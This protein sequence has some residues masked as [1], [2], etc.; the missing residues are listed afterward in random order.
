MRLKLTVILITLIIG[1]GF[2]AMQ[3]KQTI[4]FFGDS[5]TEAGVKEGGYISLMKNKLAA[6]GITNYNLE[7]AGIGGNK[8]YDLYLRM[9]EDVLSK[10]PTIVV[11]WVGVNDVWHK[12]T[13]LT[14]TDYD[15]FG[16]F[17][18]A[19]I[20]KL[21]DNNIRVIVCTPA[22]IGEKTDFS[23]ELDGDLNRYSEQIRI[24]ASDTKSGLIDLRKEFHNYNLKNNSDNNYQGILTT[25]GVHLN[26][27]GNQFVAD[28]MLKAITE[29]TKP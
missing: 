23:N 16:K 20:K 10:K 28:L 29:K 7:G 27:K 8:V 15:K 21:K 26:L 14:G 13:H 1:S 12:R 4:I 25:D 18:R 2:M 9:E 24:I 22:V 6:E 19:I 11:I 17:Y 5:I 3:K